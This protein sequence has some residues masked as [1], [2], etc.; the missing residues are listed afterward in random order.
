MD[1]KQSNIEIISNFVFQY[2][3]NKQNQNELS[4]LNT[5][6]YQ[7]L[8]QYL[9]F[10]NYQFLDNDYIDDIIKYIYD[11]I[12]ASMAHIQL[13]QKE[14]YEHTY[15]V[16]ISIFNYI[17][18]SLELINIEDFREPARKYHDNKVSSLETLNNI[19]KK[20]NLNDH[21][22]ETIDSINCDLLKNTNNPQFNLDYFEPED[23]HLQISL[24]QYLKN[25]A[26]LH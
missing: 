25:K 11:K 12:V 7:Y 21:S 19:I 6:F 10:K 24:E 26:L 1:E 17:E 22:I 13:P 2:I 20:L 15:K 16:L 5:Q 8:Q 14:A 3:S 23:S 18:D 9:T 4:V